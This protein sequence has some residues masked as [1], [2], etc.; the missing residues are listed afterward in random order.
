M[1]KLSKKKKAQYIYLIPAEENIAQWELIDQDEVDSRVKQNE[2][3]EEGR[4]FKI[5]KELEISFTKT[6]H[7]R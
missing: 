6:T 2:F 3:E 4:L 5:D 1:F 7:L